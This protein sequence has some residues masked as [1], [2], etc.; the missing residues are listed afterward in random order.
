[1]PNIENPLAWNLGLH[2]DGR[3]IGV[4]LEVAGGVGIGGKEKLTARADREAGEFPVEVLTSRE[5]IDLQRDAV[6][7][8]SGEYHLP[9]GP[10]SGPVVEVT[11]PW[12][13]EDMDTGS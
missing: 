5:A 12:V 7:G 1:M 2:G 9:A 11:R 4:E 6:L 3:S 8:A 10:E 13:G